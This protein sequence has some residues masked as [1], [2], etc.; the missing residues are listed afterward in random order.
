MQV[1]VARRQVR[2]GEAFEQ[3]GDGR[4]PDLAR[5]LSQR[6]ERHGHTG[7]TNQ[8][9]GCR[10]GFDLRVRVDQHLWPSLRCLMAEGNPALNNDLTRAQF[11]AH[12]QANCRAAGLR[13]IRDYF[14]TGADLRD[15]IERK[16][17]GT[18]R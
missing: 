9:L 15:L 5:G 3:G 2:T 13:M 12:V 7:V 18:F 4:H 14:G 8:D 16:G 11:L 17:L 6:G 10:V 1:A